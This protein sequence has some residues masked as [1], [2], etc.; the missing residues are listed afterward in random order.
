M[1][2]SG[3]YHEPAIGEHAKASGDPLGEHR[4]PLDTPGQVTL[5]EHTRAQ[6][7]NQV[8]DPQPGQ[9]GTV[10]HRGDEAE[11]ALSQRLAQKLLPP[12][13][14]PR[15]ATPLTTQ[16]TTRA[17]SPDQYPLAVMASDSATRLP[18][19]PAGPDPGS[20]APSARSP[21]LPAPA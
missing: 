21:P 19:S 20:A 5:A 3:D 17:C 16:P 2:V 9:L 10:R 4:H 11:P 8:A 7:A 13:R 12:Q 15:L 1:A 18:A 14:I 6:L